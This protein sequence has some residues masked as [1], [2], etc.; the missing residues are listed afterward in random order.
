MAR[1][2]D[3]DPASHSYECRSCGYRYE[4][5]EGVA[6][7]GIVRGTPFSTLPDN[8]LCLVCRS[9]KAA[10]VDV[11]PQNRPSGF[12]QNLNYGLGVNR[13]TP[14][15]KTILIFGGLVLAA[16]F[17]LSFYSLH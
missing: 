6:K 9:P 14:G 12:T 2:L 16:A 17:L 10:F 5:A 8:F 13:L 1:P 4:P 11:G 3:S 7:L 15:Q